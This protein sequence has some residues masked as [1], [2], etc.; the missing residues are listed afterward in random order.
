MCGQLQR[1]SL[2]YICLG[3]E[4][5]QTVSQ[6][7]GLP[8]DTL[9]GLLS[10]SSVQIRLESQSLGK[11]SRAIALTSGH[12][13]L[14]KTCSGREWQ[15]SAGLIL[16]G[17]QARH[18]HQPAP[19]RRIDSAHGVEAMLRTASDTQWTFKCQCSLSISTS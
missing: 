18:Q 17:L 19:E 6:Y 12:Q 13:L 7:H 14:R 15:T 10:F 4:A 8:E 1:Y 9:Q 3:K 16:L 2:T 5:G 11:A